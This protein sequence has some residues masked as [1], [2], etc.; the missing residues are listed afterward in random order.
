MSTERR[1][2]TRVAFATPA[3]LVSPSGQF[4]VKVHDLS[5]K[6]ALVSGLAAG[7]LPP[8]TQCQLVVS[9]DQGHD[10]ITMAVE[11][12]HIEGVHV[13]LLCRSI[14]LDSMTHLRRLIE[15]HLA[16]P[17]MLDRELQAL[18]ATST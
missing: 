6:G 15:Y 1:H 10:R 8:G 7:A 9:L 13:G 3:Q 4:A 14:D 5:F 18:L 11:V 2:F 16:A 17:A 12:A